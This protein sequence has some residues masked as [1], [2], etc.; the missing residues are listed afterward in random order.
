MTE[1]EQIQKPKQKLN[2]KEADLFADLKEKAIKDIARTEKILNEGFS[3]RL[4][5]TDKDNVKLNDS[6]VN[7]DLATTHNILVFVNSKEAKKQ[8]KNIVAMD[9][10]NMIGK[11]ENEKPEVAVLIKRHVSL[12]LRRLTKRIL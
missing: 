6:D 8:L 1:T 9:F 7:N 11:A 3:Y 12:I 5:V 4:K 10:N 2:S